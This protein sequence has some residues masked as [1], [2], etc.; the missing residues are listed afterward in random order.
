MNAQ[1]IAGREDERE[2]LDGLLKSG[3]AEFL[4]VYG[5]RRVGKTYLVREH[6]RS[7]MS[8]M[9][10][11]IQ[12]ASLGEQMVNF[13]SAFEQ[14]GGKGGE[15]PKTW[16]AAFSVLEKFLRMRKSKKKGVVFLDELPWLAGRRSGFLPALDHFWNTYLSQDPRYVLVVCG[17]AAS[18]MLSKII[19]SKGGLHNRVTSRMRLEPFSLR[20]TAAFLQM[21]NVKATR[22][23][24]LVLTMA[25][26]GIPH[27]LKEVKPGWS[28]AQSIERACLDR[29]GLLRDEFGRL[30][31]ALF[32]NPGRHITL[33]RALAKHPQVLDRIRLAGEYP[34]G[35]RLSSTLEELVEAGFV[36]QVLPFGK[37]L[38]D[39]LYRLSDEF[40][41]FYLR[42]VEPF[43]GDPEGAF[44]SRLASASWRAWSGYAME[45]VALRHMPRIKE[46]MGI[47]AVEASHAGWLHRP[48]PAFPQGAQVDWLID[49]ADNTINLIEVKFSQAP[50]SITK[51]Y[52]DQLRRKLETFRAVTGT[53]KNV[54]LTFLTPYGLADNIYSRELAH[55]SLSMEA[56][57]S[58]R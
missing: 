2:H 37:K 22:Y 12:G 26:G 46:A 4:V 11:G 45:S 7:R 44:L 36:T 47:G 24:L 39:A 1:E 28:I 54:L 19:N 50:F 56:L 10:T 18:W 14:Y 20:E 21:R 6:Y 53:R 38:R 13:Q 15:P 27:Y 33:V 16:Q 17:S 29:K 58:R 8:F 57:S 9:M 52:A 32:E 48:T 3:D 41:L 49:R 51:Q 55:Q 31:P 30:Y 5:R 42:C 35:G 34:S 23:D 25:M 40:S 43:R